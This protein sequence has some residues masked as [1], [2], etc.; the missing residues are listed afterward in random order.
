M[1]SLYEVIA[2]FD[3]IP[4]KLVFKKNFINEK[5]D[6]IFVNTDNIFR[7]SLIVQ[8]VIDFEKKYY[9]EKNPMKRTSILIVTKNSEL[10]DFILEL[11]TL[12]ED[13][14]EYSKLK[15]RQLRENDIFC[16][17]NDATFAFVYWRDVLANYYNSN[18]P[19]IIPTHYIFP[20]A[21]GRKNFKEY[22]RGNRN[23][24]GRKD[25]KQ[26]PVFLISDILSTAYDEELAF[27]HV[28]IDAETIKRPIEVHK[29][30]AKYTVFFESYFDYRVP[31][32]AKKID[33]FYPLKKM[34]MILPSIKLVESSFDH[35]VNEII[36]K[37][38]KLRSINFDSHT[39]RV[40]WKLLKH[41]LRAPVESVL[42]DLVAEFEYNEEKTDDILKELKDSD[43]RYEHK[44]FEDIIKN[45]EDIYNKYDFDRE[46]PKFAE[47]EVWIENALKRE[48]RIL[49][50][51]DGKIETMSLR[52]KLAKK[53]KIDISA[54]ESVSFKVLNY[55]NLTLIDDY[56]DEVL[57]TSL[58][59]M[60]DLII[61]EKELGSK[62]DF[63]LY[64][65]ELREIKKA[66]GNLVEIR[67]SIFDLGL[68]NEGET[69]YKKLYKKFRTADSKRDKISNL[70]IDTLSKSIIEIP[71]NY[72]FRLT[73]QYIG[74]NG[75]SARLITFEDGHNTFLKITDEINFRRE[76][77][78]KILTKTLNDLKEKDEVI[79][80]NGDVREDLYAIFIKNVNS[81]NESKKH[82]EVVKKW[83]ELYE[84]KFVH[85]K[86]KDEELFNLMRL[87]GW[88]KT[89]KEILKN[90]RRGIS[91]GPRDQKDILILGEVLEIP[92][93]IKDID[94]YYSSMNHIRTEARNAARLLN[95]IIYFSNQNLNSEDN[96]FLRKYQLTFEEVQS[97]VH[98][99]RVKHISSEE[100]I[101]KPKET[102]KIFKGDIR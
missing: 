75:I 7:N 11:E 15:G 8:N 25:N 42:Y 43:S 71:E 3:D 93:F 51:V 48:S 56:Y 47:I 31:F 52:E 38:D 45:F 64:K 67:N 94:F 13:V 90:W 12:T 54:L 35:E 68:G 96:A 78:K 87:N 32:V 10:I 79:L 61:L 72:S 40:I 84:D 82:F 85:L 44:D 66:L 41:I 24:L 65:T 23:K 99:K 16:D 95:K 70:S 91:Y 102:G 6:S 49:V 46:S 30:S 26:K 19:A 29:I 1:K 63:I 18:T 60:K 17:M 22:S 58:I 50:L 59:D 74:S 88:N 14:Y 69:I 101:V 83:R 53:F 20:I 77:G 28:F 27:D 39:L 36:E 37:L 57:V 5:N 73:K 80:I 55:Q 21:K 4:E 98:I 86:M 34:D 62:I 89:S 9:N 2:E 33:G 97:A 76:D 92:E 100:Y 81:R